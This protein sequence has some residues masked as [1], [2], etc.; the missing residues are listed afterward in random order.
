MRLKDS[1]D[2]MGDIFDNINIL[3]RKEQ[4]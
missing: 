1:V 3:A 2:R 4:G